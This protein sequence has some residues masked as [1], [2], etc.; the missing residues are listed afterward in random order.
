MKDVEWT[1]SAIADLSSIFEYVSKDS[2]RYANH[3]VERIAERTKQIATFPL[4]GANV[5]EYQRDDIREIVEFSWRVIYL[6]CETK[7]Y[8]LAVVHGSRPLSDSPNYDL[9]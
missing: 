5:P 2:P 8:I 9:E 6:D 7:V 4:S 3:V 1:R